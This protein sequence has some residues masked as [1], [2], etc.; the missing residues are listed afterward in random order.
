MSIT[1][2]IADDLAEQLKGYEANLPEILTL[3]VRELRARKET[4]YNG[5]NSILEKLASL[6]SPQEVLA[7][8]PTPQVQEHIEALLEKNRTHGLSPEEQREWDRYEYVEHLVR[9]A[10]INAAR[11]L[12]EASGQ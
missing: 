9:L 4:G 2:T 6:P 12:R 10:K 8:R 7:L 11:K 5:L 3:G 1:V